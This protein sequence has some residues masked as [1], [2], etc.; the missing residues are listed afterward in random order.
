MKIAFVFMG[1][2][3]LGVEYLS[4]AAR[5][6]G[7]ET[8]LYFDPAAFSGKLMLDN[9]FLARLTDRRRALTR[10]VAAWK[11]HA[12]AFSCFTGNYQWALETAADLRQ[13]APETKILFGGVHPTSVPHRV[14]ENPFVDALL[15]GEGE[16]AFNDLLDSVVHGSGR[17][18][19]GAWIRRDGEIVSL[20]PN[21]PLADLDALPHPDK[22]LFYDQIPALENHYLIM[23]AR[24]CPFSCTYCYKSLDAA[25]PPGA[26]PVRTRSVDHVVDE[27]L[28]FKKRGRMKMVVFRDDVFGTRRKWLEEFCEKYPAKIGL[29]YF[30]YTHPGA[31]D[32]ARAAMLAQSGCAFTTMGVQSA[33]PQIRREVLNRNYTNDQVR[34]SVAALKKHKI[35]VS[36]DHIAGLPGDTPEILGQAAEL[37]ADLHPDR[38]LT[39]WLE[40]FPGTAILKIARERGLLTDADVDRIERGDSGY[41]YAGGKA[42]KAGDANHGEASGRRDPFFFYTRKKENG[43]ADRE[44]AAVVNFMNLIPLLPQ[45]AARRLA[46]ARAWKRMPALPAAQI[47][48]MTANAIVRRDPFFAYNLL[49]MLSRKRLIF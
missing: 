4:A 26:N 35:H 32:D 44:M 12:A 47:A 22:F 14:M 42:L 28:A 1:A 36:L 29:P 15:V 18:V 8:R 13:G 46:R 16:A 3:N 23:G 27:L 33:D 45:G 6:A 20:P 17:A 10:A 34:A 30:C 48:L 2:E 41:R 38:L 49:Y 31:V 9:R 24:G 25:A 39:F 40:C 7:H 43:P 5:A 37:Y 19:P 11:P 21:P